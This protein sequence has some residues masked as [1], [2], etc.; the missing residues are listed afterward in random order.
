MFALPVFA[1][2]LYANGTEYQNDRR[3]DGSGIKGKIEKAFALAR[4][5]QYWYDVCRTHQWIHRK[6]GNR[7]LAQIRFAFYL[8]D[9]HGPDY[10]QQYIHELGH[11]IDKTG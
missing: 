11:T 8:L 3:T 10:Y 5:Y 6:T 9:Q 7:Y 2:Q 4:S 1:H